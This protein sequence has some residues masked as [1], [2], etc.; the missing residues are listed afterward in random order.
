MTKRSIPAL[1]KRLWK[2]FSEFIRRLNADEDGNVECVTCGAI[3]HWKAMHAGHYIA[4]SMGTAIYFDERNVHPQCPGC[5]LYKRGNL[6]RYAIF[7]ESKYGKG[8]LQDLDN[9]QRA[10]LKMSTADYEE[11]IHEYKEK[12]RNLDGFV[13]GGRA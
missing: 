7:L 12:L 11:K 4:K 13:Y 6:A 5:N 1:K 2:Y 10:G 8:I 3:R 9:T